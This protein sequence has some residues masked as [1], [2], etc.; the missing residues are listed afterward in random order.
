MTKTYDV[1]IR[2]TITKTVTTEDG[3]EHFLLT[4]SKGAP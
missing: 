2:A 1:V 4:Y 3:V